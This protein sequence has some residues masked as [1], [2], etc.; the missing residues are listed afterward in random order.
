MRLMEV[1]CSQIP[2]CYFENAGANS[3]YLL[4]SFCPSGS[5]GRLKLRAAACTHMYMGEG[6]KVCVWIRRMWDWLLRKFAVPR[7]GDFSRQQFRRSA[8][9]PASMCPSI[10]NHVPI[11]GSSLCF[12]CKLPRLAKLGRARRSREPLVSFAPQGHWV[13][14]T[15]EKVNLNQLKRLISPLPSSFSEY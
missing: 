9:S 11:L 2:V 7:F 6:E 4:I 8:G 1:T 12:A 5:C 15:G 10:L 14:N 13:K 3:G